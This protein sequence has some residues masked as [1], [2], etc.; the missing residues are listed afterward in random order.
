MEV[1]NR[2]EELKEEV[3]SFEKIKEEVQDKL[4]SEK[5]NIEKISEEYKKLNDL[6]P[7]LEKRKEEVEQ[8]NAELEDRFAKMFEKF[9]KDMSEINEKRGALEQIV[10][11]KEKDIEERDQ[12]LIEKIAALEENENVLKSRKSELEQV[13]KLV[14]NVNQQKE[15]MQNELQKLMIEA[16][17]R[18]TFNSDIRFETDLLHKKRDTL[19]KEMRELFT[20]MVNGYDKSEERRKKIVSEIGD[21]ENQLQQI[22]ERVSDATNELVDVQNAITNFRH[23]EEIYKTEISKFVSIKKKLQ[24]EIAKHQIILQRFQKI[25]DKLKIDQ[26]FTKS[27]QP[28]GPYPGSSSSTITRNVDEK[29]NTPIYKI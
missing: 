13:E 25:R 22:K 8:S 4:E 27:K 1:E 20:A 21:Y 23:E 29:S 3:R 2:N 28:A 18:K 24:D 16:K 26:V 19:D 9:S 14:W 6:V 11:K 15:L 12:A 10:I 5:N 17:E 7:L